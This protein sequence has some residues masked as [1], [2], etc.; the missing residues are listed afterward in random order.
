M[1]YVNPFAKE[2]LDLAEP[3]PFKA[4]TNE[5][6]LVGV[7]YDQDKRQYKLHKNMDVDLS[8]FGIYSSF[9]CVYME[10]RGPIS[11]D[12]DW[13]VPNHFLGVVVECHEIGNKSRVL[14]RDAF[15]FVQQP[16][17][18]NEKSDARRGSEYPSVFLF[19]IQ[20]MSRMNFRRTMPLTSNFVSQEG[21]FE[22]E[23]YNKVGDNTF[24]N[25]LVMLTG[26][27]PRRYRGFCDLRTPGCL[28]VVSFL[29]N[30]FHNAGYLTVFA[31][32]L[33]SMPTFQYVKRGFLHQPV[34]FYLRPFLVIIERVL[35][36]VEHL[37]FNYC[38]G[39][40]H[41]FSYVFDFAKQLIQ[42]FVHEQPKPLFGLFWTSS[43][44]RKDFRGGANLDGPFVQYLEE[45]SKQG[46]FDRAV[47]ILFSDQGFTNGPLARHYSGF[48]EERL[49][50]LH[51]YLPP[52]YRARYP[53][54]VEALKLNRNRLSSSYDLYLS[55]RHV[56][57]Q[58][59]PG[60]NFLEKCYTSQSL[61]RVLPSNRSCI[62]ANILDFW[63]T[64]EPFAQ[65]PI[66]E[67]VTKLAKLSMYRM[68]KY[69]L[70]LNLKEDC[71]QLKLREV[72]Q[73][74]RMLHFD[75]L[76]VEVAAPLQFDV[77]RLVFTTHPNNGMFRSTV[78]S[79]E[80]VI[81]SKVSLIS[82]L[83]SYRNKSFCVKDALAKKFCACKETQ[84]SGLPTKVQKVYHI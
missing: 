19:G 79:K 50:M 44:T 64:C 65:V 27:S 3:L 57:E 38:L 71:H 48:L 51:I 18:R 21:W 53:S 39:R 59:R 26:R 74:D 24:S 56:L 80:G 49:P 52:W 72:L 61:L 29:W 83:D 82:R 13:V 5:P 4:C 10:I 76:G 43:F 8:Q 84:L 67:M 31:E 16:L 40:R 60:L 17:N 34:N 46:L 33:P 20:S 63:C 2:F 73:A 9:G 41:S 11:F 12:Q 54:A 6:S 22:M 68:N 81:I 55:I 23:G 77:Y 78:Y 1:P 62:H 42:R 7:L 45:F 32:D 25:L 36:T 35:E 66:T 14:Q 47:V 28:D 70:K 37:G 58:V 15:S 30:H 69:I 75:E